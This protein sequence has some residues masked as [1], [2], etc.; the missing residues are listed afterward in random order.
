MKHLIL[1]FASILLLITILTSCGGNPSLTSSSVTQSNESA[2]AV[3]NPSIARYTFSSL[4]DFRTYCNTGSTNPNDYQAKQNELDLPIFKMVKDAFV[5]PFELIPSLDS[6]KIS[7]NHVE[8]VTHSQYGYSLYSQDEQ[9]VLCDIYVSYLPDRKYTSVEEFSHSSFPEFFESKSLS[10]SKI[11]YVDYFEATDDQRKDGSEDS[12]M[13]VF[14]LN[15]RLVR[16]T[17]YKG[18]LRTISIALGDY[19]VHIVVN[20]YQNDN[21]KEISPLFSNSEQRATLIREM[22]NYLCK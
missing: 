5:D 4:E 10:N 16:Y 11:Y 13:F 14:M 22:S 20:N 8:V 6:E 19:V 12:T 18:E 2:N 1:C 3:E 7:V 21:L 15:E 17:C 9:D